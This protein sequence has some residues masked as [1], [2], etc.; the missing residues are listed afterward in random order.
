METPTLMSIAAIGAG[1]EPAHCGLFRSLRIYFLYAVPQPLSA[2]SSVVLFNAVRQQHA[3]AAHAK[4][5]R[6]PTKE[7]K[8]Q[9]G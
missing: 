7:L 5:F 2:L 1:Y 4:L 9:V 6:H 3:I 8:K